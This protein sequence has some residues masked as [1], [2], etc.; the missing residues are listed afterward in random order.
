MPRFTSRLTGTYVKS[1]EAP[2]P[3]T[4]KT[5]FF[6][7]QV[8]KIR[9]KLYN[10]QPY[11]TMEYINMRVYIKKYFKFSRCVPPGEVWLT[12]C[13]PDNH[14]I[15]DMEVVIWKEDH[16]VLFGGSLFNITSR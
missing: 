5:S 8:N 16:L 2:L 15:G 1:L 4:L 10:K 11:V 6:S 7:L 9:I 3:F 14:Q 13:P 12:G